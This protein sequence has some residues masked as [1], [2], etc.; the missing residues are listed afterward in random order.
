MPR[1]AK[2]HP[3]NLKELNSV[4]TDEIRGFVNDT[5]K[6][7]VDE[8]ANR[9]T[10]DAN[11][12][13]FVNLRYGIRQKKKH[14]W[15]NCA[16]YSLPLI[17][18]DIQRIKPSYVNLAYNV[19]PVV[20]FE[21]Y[22]PEDV[23]PARK[24]ELL[25]DWRMRTQVQFFE[26]YVY[27]IDRM[28]EQGA[29]I[30]KVMWRFETNKY[31]EVI[32]LADFPERVLQILYSP[33]LTDDALGVII[34]EELTIDMTF[35]ENVA[36]VERA[37]QAF[38]EG[39]TRIKLNLLET[40][41]NRPQAVAR[42]LRE[43]IT[44]PI[45]TVVLEDNID[46]ARWIDDKIWTTIN[47]LKI[48][49]RDGKYEEYAD[50]DIEGWAGKS[51]IDKRVSAP[52]HSDDIVLLHET[53]VWYDIDN[54][55][56]KERCIA[57]WPDAAPESVLRFIELPYDHGQWPY[58]LVKREL[59]DP[60]VYSSRGIPHLGED[61]QNGISTAFN[62][63]VDNGTIVNRPVVVMQKNTVSNV[64]NR[65]YI[66]GEVVETNGP[67]QNYEIRQLL[68]TSQATLFQ[69]AQFL[70][71]W[72]DQRI[73]TMQS[74]MSSDA[75][76]P[77]SG[78]G[79]KKTA[80]EVQSIEFL[81]AEAQSLSLQ[82]FQQQMARV[83]YQINALYDQYGD[84]EEEILITGQQPLKVSR[85]EIQGRFNIV[86]NGRLD[87]TNPAM[88]AAKAFNLIRVFANDPD[89][90]Q[91]ELKKLFLAD[92]DSRISG[93]ILMTPEEIQQRDQA[94]MQQQQVLK[95]EMLREAVDQRRVG[96]TLDILKEEALVEI[97]G[98]KFAQD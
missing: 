77:G 51:T 63:A 65:R 93:K 91:Y 80:K 98:K 15:S 19:S 30:Y 11:I 47:E 82:V 57:T 46:S 28:L 48:A 26:Q 68:N 94:M 29:V 4:L 12:D 6:D 42:S 9:A 1:D 31:T 36:E 81:H 20:T 61:Y 69:Q 35:E 60:G 54:D 53:C 73:G 92:Y 95:Q 78:R 34:Q 83:Y 97:H 96:D 7:V 90:K 56:I 39:K 24:R 22:G 49:M 8:S 67:P 75:N 37:I 2:Q 32:D 17:D 74:A 27:G 71:S 62:Q 70:K 88:R 89:I 45:D 43:D 25:F 76:L 58:T 10:W 50:T 18:S 84:D 79:G 64:R 40:K 38:R 23:E 21:P 52:Y 55:G 13:R 85:R 33:D 5:S 16:N 87:N 14:P 44:I 86:P 66:P 3:E 41:E 59:N 72:S